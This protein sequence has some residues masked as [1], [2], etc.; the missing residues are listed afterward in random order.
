MT[1]LERPSL[2]TRTGLCFA[3]S[4]SLA[5]QQPSLSDPVSLLH[6]N[7]QQ[8]AAWANEWLHSDDARRLAWGAWLAKQDRQTA[9][10][11]LL[12]EK[13]AE[14]QPAEGSRSPTD[15]DRHDALLAVLDALIGL[16]AAV[17]A[18]QAR[19]LYP[20]FPAQSLILLLRSPGPDGPALLDIARIA[21]ANWNWLAAGN[22]LVKDRTPGFAAFLLSRFTQ[23]LTITVVDGGIGGFSASAGSECGFSLRAPKA[24]WPAVGLYLLSQ[25]PQRLPGVTATYLVGGDTPVY[26]L[27]VEPGNY[28][29]PGDDPGACDDGN[30]D[31]YRAQYLGRL[32]ASASPPIKLDAYPYT[33]I[34]WKGE[35]DYRQQLLATVEQQSALFRRALAA[36]EDPARVLGP[37]ETETWKPRIEIL[38]RDDR[39]NKSVLLPA[40]PEQAGTVSVRTNFTR[41]LD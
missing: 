37:G 14:Y 17:P 40:P 25:F 33:T 11:P 22:E 29:N 12:N 2:L 19:K 1:W 21:K 32:M 35:T 8:R 7:A 30:R 3:F 34:E 24:S 23:H 41:P 18:D 26:Y 5:A 36:V 39:A 4:A 28:D 9:L 16:G 31:Q 10:I 27:R 6:A 13:V 20:E 38:V 15:L